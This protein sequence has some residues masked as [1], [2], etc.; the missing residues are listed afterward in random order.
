MGGGGVI[1]RYLKWN[2]F[3]LKKV[4]FFVGLNWWGEWVSYLR[5]CGKFNI[6]LKF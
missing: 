6:I 1:F 3:L 4:N 5:I 2:M